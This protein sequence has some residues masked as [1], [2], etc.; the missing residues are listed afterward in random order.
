MDNNCTRET[1]KQMNAM[2]N[3]FSIPSVYQDHTILQYTCSA[4]IHSPQK[5]QPIPVHIQESR[6]QHH[7]SQYLTQTPT[8]GHT[9]SQSGYQQRVCNK[10]K[11]NIHSGGLTRRVNGEYCTLNL[12][13]KNCQSRAN[14]QYAN[15]DALLKEGIGIEKED[16]DH[17]KKSSN[18]LQKPFLGVGRATTASWPRTINVNQ[19][20]HL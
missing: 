19:N 6:S 18:N 9:M 5:G 14:H 16:H 11:P 20:T 1:T 8:K 15:N 3:Q 4:R 12:Q 17:I 2:Q 10:T 7:Q 13:W